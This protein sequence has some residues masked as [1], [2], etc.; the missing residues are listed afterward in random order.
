[1]DEDRGT[2][3]TADARLVARVAAHYA[4]APLTPGE[5][6][7]LDTALRERIGAGRRRVL[8]LPA[9]GAAAAAALL[10]LLLG[11]A[12]TGPVEIA[13]TA[14]APQPAPKSAPASP[15]ASSDWELRLLDPAAASDSEL[16]A[17]DEDLPPDYVAIAG[18]FL[19]S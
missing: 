5:R 13:R 8:W 12:P 17:R 9:F 11:R 6:A 1:M 10:A 18:A 3:D 4:P 15:P 2:L 16:G 7:R 14:A 19:D